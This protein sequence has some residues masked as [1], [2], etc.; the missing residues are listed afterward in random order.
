VG[1]PEK[2]AH[3]SIITP[4]VNVFQAVADLFPVDV[5]KRHEAGFFVAL[6]MTS[7][8]VPGDRISGSGRPALR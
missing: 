2:P 4:C 6:G 3:P 5:K 8:V 1:L 7:A